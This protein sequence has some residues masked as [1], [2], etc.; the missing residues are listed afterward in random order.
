MISFIFS[1]STSR[2]NLKIQK[3]ALDVFQLSSPS[4]LVLLVVRDAPASNN[5]K[6]ISKFSLVHVQLSDCLHVGSLDV[7]DAP[8]SYSPTLKFSWAP[9]HELA[10]GLSMLLYLRFTFPAGIFN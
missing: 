9:V 8:A 10:H 4:T 1:A 7:G 3:L 5:F 2:E 6:V